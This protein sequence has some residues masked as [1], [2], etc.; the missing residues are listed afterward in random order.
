MVQ[1]GDEIQFSK[2]VGAVP[3]D[4]NLVVLVVLK[5]KEVY[6]PSAKLSFPAKPFGTSVLLNVSEIF[7][8]MVTLKVWSHQTS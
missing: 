2:A 1:S 6:T 3:V 5:S 4:Y 7:Q 8:M